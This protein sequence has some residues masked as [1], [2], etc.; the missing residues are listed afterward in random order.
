MCTAPSTEVTAGGGPAGGI[1]RYEDYGE[2]CGYYQVFVLEFS[3]DFAR[4]NT[5]YL[6][7]WD[8]LF[9]STDRGDSWQRLGQGLN[10]TWTE[11][12]V[13]SPDFAS[14]NTL[15]FVARNKDWST[16]RSPSDY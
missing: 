5:L 6:G 9:R 15:F 13:L 8:G 10:E 2:C 16:G 1:P 3:P 12:V 4:D 14:D 11:V 7:T